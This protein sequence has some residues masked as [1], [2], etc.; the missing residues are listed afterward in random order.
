MNCRQL[1]I[2]WSVGWGAF[3]LML[4]VL[5]LRSYVYRDSEIIDLAF[6]NFLQ[7]R[8][9][10][11]RIS[12]AL[13]ELPRSLADWSPDR[14]M[15]GRHFT[16]P[17]QS[18]AIAIVPEDRPSLI[19]SFIFEWKQYRDG[20]E[21]VIPYWFL[22]A[23]FGAVVSAPWTRWPRRFGLRTLLIATTL[24]SVAIALALWV[25]N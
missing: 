10:S 23:V 8:S 7:V 25:A 3:A 18:F 24:V 9:E 4:T 22:I 5:W 2:A 17:E 19:S 20:S 14:V 16:H 21:I 1:R 13:G 6:S 15:L 11:G 12:C